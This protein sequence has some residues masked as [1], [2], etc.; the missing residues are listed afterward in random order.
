MHYVTEQR[1]REI[2]REENRGFVDEIKGYFK[3]VVEDIDSKMFL[4]LEKVENLSDSHERLRREV[5]ELK[6]SHERLKENH[7][8]LSMKVDVIYNGLVSH[9]EDKEIH[10]PR[11]KPTRR[12]KKGT[13]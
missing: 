6:D 11:A 13:K 7:E 12:S 3:A 10:L 9:M 5:E 8:R 4:V 2:V 1:V